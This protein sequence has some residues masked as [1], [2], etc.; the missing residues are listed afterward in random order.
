MNK[1]LFI[2][3]GASVAFLGS[4]AAHAKS[5]DLHVTG[6]ITPPACNISL[7]SGGIF[8]YGAIDGST[9]NATKPTLLGKKELGVS[10]TCS[11]PTKFALSVMDNR[12]DTKVPKI[13]AQAGNHVHGETVTYGL[14]TAHGKNLGGYSITISNVTS[15]SGPVHQIYAVTSKSNWYKS[16]YRNFDTEGIRQ[17]FSDSADVDAPSP[18]A[19]INGTLTVQ[20]ALTKTED[21]DLSKEIELDGS[22]TLELIIL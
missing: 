21:L 2:L 14:G 18:F 10:V 11:A 12:S 15:D 16:K 8:D 3:G 5:A 19:H 22:A 1:S 4:P 9:L 13:L 7:P 17:S 20:A 6:T